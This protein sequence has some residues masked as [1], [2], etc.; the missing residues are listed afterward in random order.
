MITLGAKESEAARDSGIEQAANH[1]SG[2][3][4]KARQGRLPN[5]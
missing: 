4:R 3:L 1:R 5:I 2:I